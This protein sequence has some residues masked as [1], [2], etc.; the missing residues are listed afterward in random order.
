VKADG[1]ADAAVQLAAFVNR[2]R[3]VRHGEDSAVRKLTVDQV[4]ER[5]LVEY[6]QEQKGRA[7]K[8][9]DDYRSMV[10][11][12]QGH[13]PEVLKRPYSKSRSWARRTTQPSA[14][15]CVS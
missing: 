10:A 14:P 13:G 7:K 15:S 1:E 8:T 3:D 4:I 2:V 11:Q 12:R 6:L 9:V 5:F